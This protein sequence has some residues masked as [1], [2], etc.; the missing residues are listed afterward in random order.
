MKW[1]KE[2]ALSLLKAILVLIGCSVISG[3]IAVITHSVL[4]IPYSFVS[5]AIIVGASIV[6]SNARTERWLLRY[7]INVRGCLS[8]L[9]GTIYFRSQIFTLKYFHFGSTKSSKI[10]KITPNL[11]LYTGLGSLFGRGLRLKGKEFLDKSQVEN[12]T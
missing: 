1:L 5:V 8:K 3:A 4:T 7:Y 6:L 11:L 9:L 12:T 2:L 10:G